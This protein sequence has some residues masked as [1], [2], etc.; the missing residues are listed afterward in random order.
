M[1]S[2]LLKTFQNKTGLSQTISKDKS[3]GPTGLSHLQYKH[4]SPA[5]F[6]KSNETISKQ[7]FYLNVRNHLRRKKNGVHI[8]TSRKNHIPHTIKRPHHTYTSHASFEQCATSLVLR[9]DALI[10]PSKVQDELT[11][12]RTVA[13]MRKLIELEMSERTQVL[14]FLQRFLLWAILVD[15]NSHWHLPTEFLC[16]T[17]PFASQHQRQRTI[18]WTHVTWA[19]NFKRSIEKCGCIPWP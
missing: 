13:C 11:D 12:K 4:S 8:L 14:Q 16:Q 19:S 7:F 2:S 18:Q 15:S 17:A 1:S 6:V 9:Y 3:A 10:K 5:E